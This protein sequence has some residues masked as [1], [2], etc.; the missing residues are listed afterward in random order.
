[1]VPH[2]VL[3]GL[4]V[5][6]VVRVRRKQRLVLF[7]LPLADWRRLPVE[8]R[9]GARVAV[10]GADHVGDLGALLIL[11]LDDHFLEQVVHRVN[12]FGA[13]LR[14][15]LVAFD[16]VFRVLLVGAELVLL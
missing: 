11:V 9:A 1:M 15:L 8:R 4:R 2:A 7:L 10:A 3:A 6:H 14:T 12:T 13:R 16:V 5:M